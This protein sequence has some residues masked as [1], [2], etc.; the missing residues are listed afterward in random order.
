[1]KLNKYHGWMLVMLILN[2]KVNA[3]ANAE[4]QAFIFQTKRLVETM[5]YLGTPISIGDKKNIENTVSKADEEKCIANIETVLTKYVLFSVVVNPES[6]VA[7]TPGMAKAILLQHG[8]ATF[9]IKVENQAGITAKLEVLSEQAK[10][11]YDGGEK[12][13]GFGNKD[14]GKTVTRKDIADRWMDM[15]LYTKAPMQNTLS[16]LQTEYFI[17]QLYS[18]DAGKRAAR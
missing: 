5:D 15:S 4:T 7:V 10:R 18:W 1:M 13:Y 12:I 8:W 17:I 16:G 11:N 3:Q 14:N 6:R 2:M 9:L